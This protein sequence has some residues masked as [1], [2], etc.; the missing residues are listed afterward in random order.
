MS[1]RK[2][3]NLR[4]ILKISTWAEL[5]S[6]LLLIASFAN[7]IKSNLNKIGLDLLPGDENC[8]LQINGRHS[9]EKIKTYKF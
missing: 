7:D 8:S 1:I 5:R 3:F 6:P 4:Y 2:V 9:D